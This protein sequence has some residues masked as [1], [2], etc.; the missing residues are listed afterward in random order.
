MIDIDEI[1]R[2][3]AEEVRLHVHGMIERK[4]I[5]VHHDGS[6]GVLMEFG[7]AADMIDV[8]VGADDDLDGKFVAAE[9]IEDAFDFVAGVDDEG[10]ARF[11]IAND[12]AIAL[13]HADGE[14]DVDHLR[15]SGVGEIQ[16][17]GNGR[18]WRDYSI[19]DLGRGGRDIR[20]QRSD[21]RRQWGRG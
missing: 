8:G 4:I 15:V 9:E 17:V 10:F 13:K 21:I 3:D 2:G 12:Q 1:G 5:A 7:K 11:G 20:Y 6:A 14:L 19:V 18:H 16:G